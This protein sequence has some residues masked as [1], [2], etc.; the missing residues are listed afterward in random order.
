MSQNSELKYVTVDETSGTWVPFFYYSLSLF[1]NI[2]CWIKRGT[3]AREPHH[4]CHVTSYIETRAF[5][6]FSSS[7]I[8]HFYFYAP[9]FTFNIFSCNLLQVNVRIFVNFEF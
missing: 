4:Q 1:F 3:P 2:F 5:F 9:I 7:N 8:K 6:F